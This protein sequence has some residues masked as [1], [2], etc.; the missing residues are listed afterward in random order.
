MTTDNV[1]APV[2]SDEYPVSVLVQGDDITITTCD[3]CGRECDDWPTT[4]GWGIPGAMFQAALYCSRCMPFSYDA[5]TGE[6]VDTRTGEI[7]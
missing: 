2:D 6:R 7:A 1:T 3:R 5:R 4:F